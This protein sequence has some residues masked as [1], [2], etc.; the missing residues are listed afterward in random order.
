MT[1]Q[2]EFREDERCGVGT[3][4]D[5]RGCD[6]DVKYGAA[7]RGDSTLSFSLSHSFTLVYSR[8]SARAHTHTN[9][10]K[11][12]QCCTRAHTYIH[13]VTHTQ[14]S[15]YGSTRRS[16]YSPSPQTSCG[17]NHTPPASPPKKSFSPH[18]SPRSPPHERDI[19]SRWPRTKPTATAKSMQGASLVLLPKS[20]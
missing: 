15:S 10:P 12:L 6:F 8:A 3:L 4:T 7:G 1:Y 11:N 19:T 16:N 13:H 14:G 20:L 9:A 18:S 17:P 2:G 5:S